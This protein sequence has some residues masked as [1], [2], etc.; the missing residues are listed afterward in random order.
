MAGKKHSR[1]NALKH[2]RHAKTKVLP[3]EDEKGYKALVRAVFRDIQPEGAVEEDLV[4]RLADS[5]WKRYC[6]EA[7]IRAKHE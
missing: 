4:M 6:M 7:Q 5:M 3:Y 2:G 1:M